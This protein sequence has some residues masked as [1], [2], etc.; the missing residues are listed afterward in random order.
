MEMDIRTLHERFQAY[1]AKCYAAVSQLTSDNTSMVPPDFEFE[2]FCEFWN[3]IKFDVQ[4][5]QTWLSRLSDLGFDA[6]TKRLDA[7]ISQA[8]TLRTY[9]SAA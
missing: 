7:I 6:E 4:K 9:P 2:Q 1:L 3:H 8:P 5:H